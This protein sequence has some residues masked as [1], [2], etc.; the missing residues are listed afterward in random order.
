ISCLAASAAFA[1]PA[2]SQVLTEALRGPL[3][4]VTTQPLGYAI[5][6]ATAGLRT[7][8]DNTTSPVNFGFASPDLNS[9]WGDEL[10]LDTGGVLASYAFSIVNAPSSLGVLESAVVEVAFVEA[11]TAKPIGSYDASLLFKP[12]VSPGFGVLVTV[13]GLEVLNIGFETQDVLV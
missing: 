8:Y 6:N 12:A 3:F 2:R 1:I 10:H 5:P 7:V 9:R 11:E 4:R 13:E